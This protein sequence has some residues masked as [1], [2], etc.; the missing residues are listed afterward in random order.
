MTGTVADKTGA[1]VPN[2]AVTITNQGTG[3]VRTEKANGDGSFN[4]LDVLPGTLHIVRRR[5]RGTLPAS[6]RKTF[7]SRSTSRCAW[8]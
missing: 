2:V 7:K 6:R 1:V 3:E 4:V 5:R 8:M